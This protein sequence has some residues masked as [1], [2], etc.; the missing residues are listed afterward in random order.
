MA[1]P[2]EMYHRVRLSFCGY[3][4][5]KDKDAV[6][7]FVEDTLMKDPLWPAEYDCWQREPRHY[8]GWV[9]ASE[10]LD[11][12]DATDAAEDLFEVLNARGLA[13]YATYFVFWCYF[14]KGA[15]D[16]HRVDKHMTEWRF[17][18]SGWILAFE[19]RCCI[20]L[21]AQKPHPPPS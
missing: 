1:V 8:Y 21:R 5:L 20:L 19:K 10:K 13:A 17:K 6:D 3:P 4:G 7:H 18:Q 12:A 15:C 2:D 11:K 16:G 9:F 14:R